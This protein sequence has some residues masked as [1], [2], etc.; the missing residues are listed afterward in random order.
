ML[1]LYASDMKSQ[2]LPIKKRKNWVEYE[3]VGWVTK[4]N[5]VW[6]T[7]PEEYWKCPNDYSLSAHKAHTWDKQEGVARA[8]AQP[9]HAAGSGTDNT[10]LCSHR[11]FIACVDTGVTICLQAEGSDLCHGNFSYDKSS[12][13]LWGVVLLHQEIHTLCFQRSLFRGNISIPFIGS[14]LHFQL[15]TV[16]RAALTIQ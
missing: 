6:P 16:M 10:Q 9:Q 11:S 14:F 8:T 12:R 3:A 1:S 4:S 5:V 13:A 2:D 15:L 7:R